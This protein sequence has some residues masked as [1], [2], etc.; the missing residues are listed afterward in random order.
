MFGTTVVLA[1]LAAC[2]DS[3]LAFNDEGEPVFDTASPTAETPADSA[4]TD[5]KPQ[6]G[7]DL[8]EYWSVR[9]TLVTTDAG[10]DL[11]G[12]SIELQFWDAGAQ[13]TCKQRTLLTLDGLEAVDS[14]LEVSSFGWFTLQVGTTE[15]ESLG[16][17]GWPAGPLE[18]GLG[19][20]DRS[21]DHVLSERGWLDADL[22][23]L[24]VRSPVDG[25][26]Y[27]VGV[28]GTEEMFDGNADPAVEPPLPPGT[29]LLETLILLDLPDAP[30]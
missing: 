8:P 22:Y 24:F 30:T 26:V 29:Y 25:Q 16:C 20:Y 27:L 23:G 19:V 4:T 17:P 15:G 12:S 7:Q 28:A 14:P 3:N 18:I 6:P 2:E 13:Q 5:G 9:G 21:L 10:P 11:E 1:A